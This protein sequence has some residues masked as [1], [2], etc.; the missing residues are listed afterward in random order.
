MN[1]IQVRKLVRDGVI[2]PKQAAII[3]M[4]MQVPR[5]LWPRILGWFI[6]GLVLLAVTVGAVAFITVMVR[7]IVGA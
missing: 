6:I 2:T 7:L 3:E 1:Q 5:R 4:Q